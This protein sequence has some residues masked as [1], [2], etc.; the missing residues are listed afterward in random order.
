MGIESIA[1]VEL[2]SP[3]IL[4]GVA[5]NLILIIIAVFLLIRLKRAKK[6]A[7]PKK[8]KESELAGIADIKP[9]EFNLERLDIKM[10]ALH[11]E[12]NAKPLSWASEPKSWIPEPAEA[13]QVIQEKPEKIP[14]DFESRAII[15]EDDNLKLEDDLP[16]ET[17][18]IPSEQRIE[19][20]KNLEIKFH[21]EQFEPLAPQKVELEIPPPEVKVVEVKQPE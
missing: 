19:T 12:K 18:E 13:K 15:K 10:D 6:K 16:E 20:Q 17:F 3:Q 1:G 21:V 7:E 8:G 11:D 5:I 2:T 4:L 14:N 9:G